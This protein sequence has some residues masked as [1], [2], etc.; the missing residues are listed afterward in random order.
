MPKNELRDYEAKLFQ[1]FVPSR[2]DGISSLAPTLEPYETISTLP[3][4]SG[5]QAV[6]D[7]KDAFEKYVA[8]II[9]GV[10]LPT[11]YVES[12]F[13]LYWRWRPELREQE[14]REGKRYLV[15]SRCLL[16]NKPVDAEWVQGTKDAGMCFAT[17]KQ[18]TV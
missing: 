15:Y 10:D 16:S 12:T 9:E 14:R 18:G 1:K 4:L 2:F 5:R 8:R 6:E 13:T 17:G 7:Y 11:S 3:F